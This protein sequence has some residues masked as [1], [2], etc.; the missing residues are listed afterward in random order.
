MFKENVRRT[1]CECLVAESGVMNNYGARGS[2]NL[3]R[4]MLVVV[5]GG[6][7]KSQGELVI[8]IKRLAHSDL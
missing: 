8:M 3:V 6:G 1:C 5:V 4:H 7:H 2:K